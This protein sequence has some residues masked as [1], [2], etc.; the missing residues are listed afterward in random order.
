[1]LS[2]NK[3]I[4]ARALQTECKTHRHPYFHKAIYQYVE[5]VKQWKYVHTSQSMCLNFG[6]TCNLSH[7]HQTCNDY[8]TLERSGQ[9]SLVWGPM[10]G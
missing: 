9:W 5:Y 7:P 4:N 8:N 2:V 10:A 1:M 6:T 3:R